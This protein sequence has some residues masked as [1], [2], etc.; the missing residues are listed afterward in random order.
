[1]REE[2]HKERN[3]PPPAG[4]EDRK[5]DLVYRQKR[6]TDTGIPQ[7]PSVYAKETQCISKRDL[8][9]RQK[10]PTDTGIPVPGPERSNRDLGAGGG[11]IFLTGVNEEVCVC[12]C[13]RARVR[14]HAR[15]TCS[16]A[17]AHAL[18]LSFASHRRISKVN[19][20]QSSRRAGEEV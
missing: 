6:P 20:Q 2:V 5:R 17:Y 1:V 19:C 10:R 4:R 18:G 13:A 14:V 11:N 3:R 7:R 16:R 15:V 9:D 8:V 12:V